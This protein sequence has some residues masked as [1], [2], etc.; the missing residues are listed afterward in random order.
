MPRTSK[1]E[2]TYGRAASSTSVQHI[3]KIGLGALPECPTAIDL[4]KSVRSQYIAELSREINDQRDPGQVNAG[5]NEK[6]VGNKKDRKKF[7]TLEPLRF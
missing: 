6:S 5:D 4:A 1:V 7:I 2:A 3:S